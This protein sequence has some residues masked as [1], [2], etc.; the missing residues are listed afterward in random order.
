MPIKYISFENQ[1]PFITLVNQI[2][3][4][5]K[6]NGDT[7]DLEKQIDIMVYKL[8]ELDYEEVLIIEPEF[9]LSE[10]EFDNYKI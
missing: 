4:S 9:G 8:Y 1:Q 7:T 10:Q 3:F 5:K 2:L 6:E